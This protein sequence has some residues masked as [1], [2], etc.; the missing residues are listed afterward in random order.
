M[1]TTLES[2]QAELAAM[3]D[4]LDIPGDWTPRQRDAYETERCIVTNRVN[5]VRRANATLAEVDP[6]IA[7]LTKWRTDLE[8]C[9]KTLCDELLAAPR[10]RTDVDRGQL[11]NREL[12]IQSADRG[13]R[14]AEG[15]GW[16]VDTLRL[17][18]LLRAAGYV[19]GPDGQLP[20][21]GALPEVERR[22]RE[23]HE[24]RDEA[25]RRLDDALREP[26]PESEPA[27]V[28]S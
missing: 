12:S 23:L 27:S 17:G 9:R 7:V 26:E 1:T 8:S 15:T 11:R 21:Y 24:R 13:R 4:S 3:R 10:P 14:V 22:L 28:A 20:W 5:E 19:A 2:L 18:E 6:L 16:S 25:Q